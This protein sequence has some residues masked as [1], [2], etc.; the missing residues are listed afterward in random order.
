[1]HASVYLPLFIAGLFGLAAPRLALRLPPAAA[2]WLLSVGGLIAAAGAAASLT[3][4][5]F[6]LVAQAQP[7]AESGH[8]SITA[9]RHEDPVL[10]PV[11]AASIA[12][13]LVLAVRFVTAGVRR[14]CALLA[15]HRLASGLPPVGQELAV[16]R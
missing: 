10:A 11:A 3:L 14:A 7:L 9:L 1:M 12:A 4:L 16:R 15:A 8:W 2:T 5:G 13:V 6:T